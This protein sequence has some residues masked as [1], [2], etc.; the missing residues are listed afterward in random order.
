MA[1]DILLY[2]ASWIPVGEDQ[3]QHLEFT[4]DIAIRMNN[5]FGKLFIIPKSLSEQQ[6][7]IKRDSAP[8]IRS[9]RNPEVKM[10]KSVDDPSGTI[11]L[12]D[13]TDTVKK[14]IMSA[15]T[16]NVGVINYD[17]NKQPGISNLLQILYLTSGVSLDSVTKKWAGNTKYGEL[18][19]AVYE[20]VSATLNKIQSNLDKV[21]EAKLQEKLESSE[22]QMQEIANKK[23]LDVQKAVGLRK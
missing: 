18:K 12:S 22:T 20:A 10:S 11:K 15:V 19:Q 3:R 9:L 7:F 21:S 1:S 13:S 17:W 5:K 2:G 6:N 8:R 4:R 23:L 14:K 16:D